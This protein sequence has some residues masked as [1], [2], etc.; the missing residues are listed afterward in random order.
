[1]TPPKFR[2]TPLYTMLDETGVTTDYD[3]WNVTA[4]PWVWGPAAQDPWYTRSSMAGLRVGGYRTER[5]T[6]GAYTAIRSDYRDAVV[7][8]DAK[9]LTAHRE[10]GANWEARIAGPWFGQNGG[11]APERASVYARKIWKEGS[12]M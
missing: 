5:Y 12:S 6:A 7:G 8:A 3:R 11:G 4:G 2:A 1:K 9:V 10:F